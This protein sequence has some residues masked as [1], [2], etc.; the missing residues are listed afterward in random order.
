MISFLKF[1]A[2]FCLWGFLAV[3]SVTLL[4]LVVWVL[5]G[6]IKGMLERHD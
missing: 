2:E 1:V 4:A 6:V 3:V 5:V